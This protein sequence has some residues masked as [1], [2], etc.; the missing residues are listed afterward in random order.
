MDTIRHKDIRD[1]LLDIVDGI[2]RFDLESDGLA[3]EGLAGEG[4][5]E[6]LHTA[7][8][9]EAP[10]GCCSRSGFGHLCYQSSSASILR[11]IDAQCRQTSVT[12]VWSCALSNDVSFAK[13]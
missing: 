5:D 13:G 12:I 2:R 7:T 3:G 11:I 4:L 1:N 10:S 8:E 6:D 9:A